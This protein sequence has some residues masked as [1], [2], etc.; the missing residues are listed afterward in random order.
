MSND[1]TRHTLGRG[2]SLASI[3]KQDGYLWKTLWEHG[4]NAALRARRRN[5]NQLAEGDVLFLPPKGR[6]TASRPTDGRHAFKRR[7]EPTRLK[8]QLLDMGEPRR[9]L[10]YTLVFGDQVVHGQTDGE[11]R[12]DQPIPGETRTAMLNLDGGAEAYSVAIGELD[13]PDVPTGVQHRL[14]NLGFDCGGESGEIGDA[15]RDALR[16]FQ[17]AQSLDETGEADAATRARLVELHV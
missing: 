5:P 10:P 3:A 13:P 9:D 15:T 12:I 17:H 11:G 8:L 2:E 1:G 4:E 6:K 7:G 16:R 14:S